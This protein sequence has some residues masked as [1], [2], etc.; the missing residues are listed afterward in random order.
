MFN[1]WWHSNEIWFFTEI[2]TLGNI[3]YTEIY[4]TLISQSLI[5]IGIFLY[6]LNYTTITVIY[7]KL[8]KEMKKETA[9]FPVMLIP[10][11]VFLDRCCRTGKNYNTT[12]GLAI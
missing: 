10:T 5:P 12:F 3:K 6:Q 8:V 11:K 7:C 1:F 9:K 4:Q 2:Q